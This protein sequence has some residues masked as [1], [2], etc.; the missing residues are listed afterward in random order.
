[1]SAPGLSDI[2]RAFLLG[3]MKHGAPDLW[4]EALAAL[5]K[6]N[7]SIAAHREPTLEDVRDVA[8]EVP[9]HAPDGRRGSVSPREAL[10]RSSRGPRE[11]F[12]HLDNSIA[13]GDVRPAAGLRH[14]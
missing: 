5:E 9:G 12:P 1:M 6:T 8:V 10:V 2:D 14:E 4:A 13:A 11:E 7:A 3:Y